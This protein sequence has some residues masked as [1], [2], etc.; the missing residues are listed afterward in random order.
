MMTG[1]VVVVVVVAVAYVV[2]SSGKHP[3]ILEKSVDRA[4]PVVRLI[5]IKD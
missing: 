5:A 4:Y 3:S 2:L 1:L